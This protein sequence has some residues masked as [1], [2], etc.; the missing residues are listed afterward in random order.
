[1]WCAGSNIDPGQSPAEK[2]I[3]ILNN[4]LLRSTSGTSCC[5]PPLPFFPALS[6][7]P[8]GNPAGVRLMCALAGGALRRLW[9]SELGPPTFPVARSEVHESLACESNIPAHWSDSGPA[10]AYTDSASI[11]R[12]PHVPLMIE[13]MGALVGRGEEEGHALRWVPISVR[14]LPWCCRWLLQA[15]CVW[16]L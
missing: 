14:T 2:K 10:A 12:G 3:S 7:R 6:C 1:M 15:G 9:R 8:S 13:G 11:C 4:T 5:L 16:N